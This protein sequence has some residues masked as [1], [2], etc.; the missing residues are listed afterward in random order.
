MYAGH[1][2]LLRKNKKSAKT[3]SFFEVLPNPPDP[4][5][6]HRAIYLAPRLQTKK[7]TGDC[8]MGRKQPLME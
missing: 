3:G 1:F 6:I 8:W 4:S 2:I 5:G 7:K